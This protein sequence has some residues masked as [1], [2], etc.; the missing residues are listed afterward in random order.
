[1]K[2]I[3]YWVSLLGLNDIIVTVIL[4]MDTQTGLSCISSSLGSY[5]VIFRPLFAFCHLGLT[6]IFTG[7]PHRP[8]TLQCRATRGPLLNQTDSIWRKGPRSVSVSARHLLEC[9][10]VPDELWSIDLGERED[11]VGDPA[12]AGSSWGPTLHLP[13]HRCA[14]GRGG[15]HH[16]Q[17]RGNLR[18]AFVLKVVC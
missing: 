13:A 15:V 11:M 18:W 17:A 10:D 5:L 4:G 7:L 1:M 12:Q 16:A 14:P 9:S 6:F 3:S 2:G 8:I